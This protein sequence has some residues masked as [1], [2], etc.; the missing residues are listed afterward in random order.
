MLLFCKGS[1]WKSEDGWISPIKK[2]AMAYLDVFK[3]NALT[4]HMKHQGVFLNVKLFF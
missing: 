2:G 3:E 4:F 1:T